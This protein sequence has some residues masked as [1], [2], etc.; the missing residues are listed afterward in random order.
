MK[1]LCFFSIIVS[2]ATT[3]AVHAQE[4]D[5]AGP[6]IVLPG[7]TIL[8]EATQIP[9]RD[10]II[11][12]FNNLAPFRTCADIACTERTDFDIAGV[13]YETNR[14]SVGV[15]IYL[16]AVHTSDTNLTLTLVNGAVEA[17]NWESSRED[18][19]ADEDSDSTRNNPENVRHELYVGAPANFDL[20]EADPGCALMLLAHEQ[21]FS[22]RAFPGV[23]TKPLRNLRS[24]AKR[25]PQL[26]G[27]PE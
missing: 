23:S 24:P 12:D 8:P 15:G 13:C 7:T 2:L 5:L 4:T 16:N 1:R 10:Q 21:P 22:F 14:Y 18:E 27:V 3:T 6:T 19:N 25:Q 17:A 20:Q 9:I 26:D 11:E